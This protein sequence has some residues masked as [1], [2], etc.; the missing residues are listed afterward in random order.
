[1]YQ[2]PKKVGKDTNQSKQS[3]Y[4]QYQEDTKASTDV[5]VTQTSTFSVTAPVIAVISG[6]ADSNGNYTGDVKYSVKGN[7]ASNEI[8]TIKPDTSFALSQ[9]GKSDIDCTVSA[10]DG[11]TAKTEFKYSDGL[12]ANKELSQDYTL[13]TKDITAGSWHGKYNTNISLDTN[14]I[15][16]GYTALYKYDLSATDSDEVAAYYCVPN[17]NTE[18]LESNNASMNVLSSIANMFK[19]MTAYAANSNVI[20][21]NGVKYT[22]SDEDTLVISGSGNMKENIQSD[23]IDYGAIQDA[24]ANEFN[25]INVSLTISNSVYDIRNLKTGE[26]IDI[27]KENFEEKK[28]LVWDTNNL[29]PHFIA[30]A[31]FDEN[32]NF[33]NAVS[34]QLSSA[35]KN[36][37]EKFKNTYG[38]SFPKNVVIQE[39]V[40]DISNNA[41]LNCTS[42]ETVELAEGVTQIGEK[43]FSGC[44]NLTII[45]IPSTVENVKQYAFENCTSLNN[46]TISDGVKNFEE[47]SFSGCAGLTNFTFPKSIEKINNIFGDAYHRCE[48]LSNIVIENGVKE[49]A[50]S[51]FAYLPI[52]TINIPNSVISFG[53]LIFSNCKNLKSVTLPNKISNISDNMF[54]GCSSLKNILIPSS[55][56]T[57]NNYAFENCTSL[58]NIILPENLT[59]I[60]TFAFRNTALT[61]INIPESVTNIKA[62]AFNGC[63]QLTSVKLPSNLAKIGICA[64][65]KCSNLNTVYIPSS[66]T[67]IMSSAFTNIKSGSTIYCE[68]QVVANLFTSS[69]Y[70]NN[71]TTIVVDASKF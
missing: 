21:Y 39:G 36:E 15:P 12:R 50:T 44:T 52:E 64:F 4:S 62:S 24:F 55:V 61:E 58:N 2:M 65:F 11:G 17:K 38:I 22:L 27:T 30:L 6:T 33:V 40:T 51:A 53:T 68:S 47:N 42:V 60:G 8:V 37:I 35:Q 1:M 46:I 28:Y 9:N 32:G 34:G 69:N 31:K 25:C 49:I 29:N 48:N 41:F 5:Y 43:A 63:S 45:N 71:D 10:K 23:L 54:S 20:E 67:S 13:S 59:E 3:K 66:V 57:I 70:N 56:I 18:K 7:I 19:P 16:E 26:K 14:V